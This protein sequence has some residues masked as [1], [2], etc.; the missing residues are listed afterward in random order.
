MPVAALLAAPIA[1]A[2]GVGGGLLGAAET[3][4]IGA[5]LGAGSG[6]AFGALTG[7]GP[8]KGAENG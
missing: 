1:E 4:G 3:A 2:L 7:E 5:A 8:A 6:A